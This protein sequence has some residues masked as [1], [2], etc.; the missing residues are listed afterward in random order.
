MTTNDWKIQIGN[1]NNLFEIKTRKPIQD[2]EKISNFFLG[3]PAGFASLYGVTNGLQSEWFNLVPFY[4]PDDVKNTWDS[5]SRANDPRNTRFL[6]GD[7][8][9]M[10]RFFVFA[11]IGAGCCACI[12][13]N[14]GSIWFEDDESLHQT[15]LDIGDF[16]EATLREVAE[17]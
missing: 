6:G 3:L 12:E 16:I 2:S 13:R 10:G 8:A 7:E 9:L 11:E 4:S 14:D 5:L 1:W 17:L 15:D